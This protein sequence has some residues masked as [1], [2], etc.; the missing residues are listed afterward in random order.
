MLL[1]LYLFLSL[2]VF[3]VLIALAVRKEVR[4]MRQDINR[5]IWPWAKAY[6][7]LRDELDADGDLPRR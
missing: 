4:G 5:A 1:A 3:P 6:Y 2:I 7:E